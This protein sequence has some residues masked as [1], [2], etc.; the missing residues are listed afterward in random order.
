MRREVIVSLCLSVHTCGGDTPARSSQGGTPARSSWGGD[1]SQGGTCLGYPPPQDRTA[2]G[3]L[4]T[5][6]SVC[7]LRSCSRTFLLSHELVGEFRWF[8][9][10][11]PML[12]NP[13][14]GMFPS[15]FLLCSLIKTIINYCYQQ[16]DWI[17]FLI[18][19]YTHKYFGGGWPRNW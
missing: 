13:I 3:V 7:L 2:H 4:D 12:L 17:L 18:K 11:Q 5:P 16:F 6:R 14:C 19:K 10:S 8:S 15:V 9:L 1:P